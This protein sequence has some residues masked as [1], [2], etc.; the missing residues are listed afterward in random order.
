MFFPLHDE[1]QS[2]TPYDYNGQEPVSYR[3]RR[4]RVEE[5]LAYNLSVS[6]AD[7]DFR[8]QRYERDL[9]GLI[10]ALLA[11]DRLDR[12]TVD[13]IV[14]RFPRDGRHLFSK[15]Q[16][17]RGIRELAPARG[18]EVDQA[19]RETLTRAGYPEYMHAFGHHI[20]RTAPDNRLIAG[21]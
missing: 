21:A 9:T 8:P 2:Y 18:W 1:L 12:P 11:V 14:A 3:R 19:A 13:R 4:L 17:V 5:R 6:P 15:S 16:I 20:G 7:F 10:E